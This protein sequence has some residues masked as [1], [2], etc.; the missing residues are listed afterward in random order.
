MISTIDKLNSRRKELFEQLTGLSEFR[1]GTISINYS[2][3]GKQECWCSKQE[4]K[5]HGPK[6]LWS[7]KIKGK[8]VSKNLKLGPEVEKYLSETE[9]YK[10]FVNICDELIEV[11]EQLCNAMPVIQLES[12]KDLEAM[13]KKQQRQL[14]KK[15]VRK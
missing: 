13:K 5:G 11:N 3:C 9:R 14:L 8:T 2:K 10:M 4:T 6:Y 15:R 12:E 1:R 7:K